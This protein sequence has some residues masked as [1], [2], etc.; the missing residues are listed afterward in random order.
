MEE[1][2]LQNKKNGMLA[3]IISVLLYVAACVGMIVAAPTMESDLFSLIIL[4]VKSIRISYLDLLC[5]LYL[6]SLYWVSL[7]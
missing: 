2:I 4:F 1:K 3:L 6:V 7:N 5:Y